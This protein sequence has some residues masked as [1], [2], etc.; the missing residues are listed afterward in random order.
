MFAGRLQ[1]G[2]QA[3]YKQVHRQIISRF[4]GGFITDLLIGSKQIYR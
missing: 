2:S 1:A 3:D 4:A